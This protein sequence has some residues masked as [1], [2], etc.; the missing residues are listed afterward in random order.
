M[1]ASSLPGESPPPPPRVFFGRDELIEKVVGFAESLTPIALIG[2][3]GI[4]KTSIALTV[5]HNDRIKRRFGD[6]RRFICYG[7]FPTSLA[8]FLQRLS[9]AI[10]A[11]IENPKD[12]APLRQFLSS[13]EMFIVLDG[14]ESVLDPRGTDGK[15]I[16]AVIEEFSQFSNICLC[17]TSRISVV[18]PY[19]EWVDIPTLSMEPACGTFYRIYNHGERSDRI[20]D[21]LEQLDFHPLSI[22]LLATVAQQNKWGIDRLA[23]EWDEN[24]TDMLQTEHDKSLAATIGSSLSSPM[25]QGLGPE[26]RDLLQSIAFFPHGVNENNLNWLFPTISTKDMFDKFCI[27]SLTHRNDGFLTMSAPLRNH[28]CSKYLKSV[29]LLPA[30]KDGDFLGRGLEEESDSVVVGGPPETELRYYRTSLRPHPSLR[31]LECLARTFCSHTVFLI[32]YEPNAGGA[33]VYM[34]HEPNTA[35]SRRGDAGVRCPLREDARSKRLYHFNFG[36]GTRPVGGPIRTH[37]QS[38]SQNELLTPTLTGEGNG[39][40]E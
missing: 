6:D 7:Q 24:R 27:L 18:P 38:Y 1:F 10:G 8:H 2:A 22:T 35:A 36:P 28:L 12:L 26:A 4:G 21:I 39:H 11:E 17:I 14:A 19:C 25:F 13:K 34:D 3:G 5:L 40:S 23:S 29:L 9:K 30:T 20:D 33:P 32:I 15:E 31:S 16:Y 37:G